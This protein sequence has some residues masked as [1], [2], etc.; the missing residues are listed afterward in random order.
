[1]AMHQPMA[2]PSQLSKG[3]ASQEKK[4]VSGVI[5]LEEMILLEGIYIAQ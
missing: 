4:R 2:M 5:L 3:G 1:M